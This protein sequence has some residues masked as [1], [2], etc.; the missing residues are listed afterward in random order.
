M[1]VHDHRISDHHHTASSAVLGTLGKFYDSAGAFWRTFLSL[2]SR[3]NALQ[4]F[5]PHALTSF[6]VSLAVLALTLLVT[7]PAAYSIIWLKPRGRKV[8]QSFMLTSQMLPAI[9]FVIAPVCHVLPREL[10]EHASGFDLG[11]HHSH[12]SVRPSHALCICAGVSL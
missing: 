9:V 3:S 7:G 10:G 11:G 2:A 8:L 4:R 1:A 12:G 6:V 5:A